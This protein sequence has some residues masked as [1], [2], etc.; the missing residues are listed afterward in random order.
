LLEYVDHEVV[1]DVVDDAGGF[2]G[3][4]ISDQLDRGI[5]TEILEDVGGISRI[6]AGQCPPLRT[7]AGEVFLDVARF[8]TRSVA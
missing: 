1:P 2:F 5:V 3:T 7:V 8:T 4:Q 6:G